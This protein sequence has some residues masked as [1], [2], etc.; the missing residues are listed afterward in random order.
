[1]VKVLGASVLAVVESAFSELRPCSRN[2]RAA[3]SSA[4]LLS[5][6]SLSLSSLRMTL[7]GRGS[8]DA[9]SGLR[10]A[11][12]D[13][14]LDLVERRRLTGD[15]DSEFWADERLSGIMRPLGV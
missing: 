1:M 9:G 7:F 8:F 14:L 4:I 6:S 2:S 12:G 10:V 5:V 11:S 15:D 13:V 3:F